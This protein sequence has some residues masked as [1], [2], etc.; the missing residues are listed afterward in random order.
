MTLDAP[1]ASTLV[2]IVADDAKMQPQNV[3]LRLESVGGIDVSGTSFAR[4]LGQC[5]AFGN[6]LRL[7]QAAPLTVVAEAAP[8]HGGLS[9]RS[10][11]QEI[12]LGLDQQTI[13]MEVLQ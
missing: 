10:S 7:M 8:A 13:R 12:A 11:T 1:P 6:E 2:R 5:F 9:W 3:M 4:S